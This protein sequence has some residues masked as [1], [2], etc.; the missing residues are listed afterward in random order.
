MRL[1]DWSKKLI[2]NYHV[3]FTDEIHSLRFSKTE[4]GGCWAEWECSAWL[5]W[6]RMT[7]TEKR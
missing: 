1:S 7:E 3:E 5:F 6:N 4:I 2:K